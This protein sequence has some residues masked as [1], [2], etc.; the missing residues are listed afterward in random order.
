MILGR[1]SS[2]APTC[3]FL[4]LPRPGGSAPHLTDQR[5]HIELARQRSPKSGASSRGAGQR[6]CFFGTMSWPQLIRVR[7]RVQGMGR[8]CTRE[9]C[10]RLTRWEHKGIQELGFGAGVAELADAPDSK[11]GVAQAAWGFKSPLRHHVRNGSR[12]S[13]PV[14]ISPSVGAPPHRRPHQSGPVSPPAATALR[15]P[16]VP[17][18]GA[19]SRLRWDDRASCSRTPRR[20]PPRSTG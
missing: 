7:A 10:L 19:R 14:R 4:E 1:S 18:A 2:Q 15:S 16:D 6:A 9:P 17:A 5:P 11:S 3:L 8:L 20:I 13:S 12:A